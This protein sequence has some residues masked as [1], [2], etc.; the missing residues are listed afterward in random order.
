MEKT[1]LTTRS[2]V[3]S[4]AAITNGIADY[5]QK[6]LNY[7][8]TILTAGKYSLGALMIMAMLDCSRTY[9]NL[10]SHKV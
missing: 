1:A 5:P 9:R 8:Y 6:Y 3:S 4:G 10:Q 7:I 2:L